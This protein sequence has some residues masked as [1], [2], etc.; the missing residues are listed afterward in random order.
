MECIY[1]ETLGRDS[2]AIAV[3]ADEAAHLKALRVNTGDHILVTNGRG[4][5]AQSIVNRVGKLDFSV[6][7]YNFIEEHSELPFRLGLAIGILD[8]RDRM[9]FALEKAVELGTTDFFPL[10]AERSQKMNVPA[11]RLEMKAIAALKQCKRARLINIHPPLL[12]ESL[13]EKSGFENCIL[14]DEDGITPHSAHLKKS[15]LIIVGPE[16]GFSDSELKIIKNHPGIISW[17]LGSRRLRAE[18]AAISALSFASFMLDSF[19]D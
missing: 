15:T 17:R 16:G 3:P 18:T 7:P 4:L 19:S 9:E 1:I 5:C 2:R 10:Q 14:A 6:E 13:L 11:A 12:L 8:N